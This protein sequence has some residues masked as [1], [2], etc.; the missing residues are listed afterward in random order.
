MP[1]PVVERTSANSYRAVVDFR[2]N[3]L[4]TRLQGRDVGRLD[5]RLTGIDRDSAITKVQDFRGKSG[6]GLLGDWV[7][8]RF[9]A[10]PSLPTAA[11]VDA[12]AG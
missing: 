9:G 11:E 4:Q 8:A 7:Q 12:L 10:Q 5:S 6:H 1:L 3:L 2:S